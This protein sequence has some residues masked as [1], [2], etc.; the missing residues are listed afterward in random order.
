MRLL[1]VLALFGLAAGGDLRIRLQRRFPSCRG[2]LEGA[3]A[4][5]GYSYLQ[6]LRFSAA[7]MDLSVLSEKDRGE[8]WDDLICG[9]L[10]YSPGKGGLLRSVSA[11]WLRTRLGSGLVLAH[12]GGWSGSSFSGA[13]KSPSIDA[14]LRPARGSW[15][16]DGQGLTG[17]GAELFVGGVDLWLLQGVSRVDPSEGGY[18]RTSGERESRGSLLEVLSALRAEWRFLGLSAASSWPAEDD[19]PSWKRAGVDCRWARESFVLAGELA[20][21]QDS[22]G[23]TTAFWVAPAQELERFRHCFALFGRPEAFPDRRGNVPV[24]EDCDLG[25]RYGLR[26]RPVDGVRVAGRLEG[27]AREGDDETE[28]S[29]E[30]SMRP[31]PRMQAV[32]G[33]RYGWEGAGRSWRSLLKLS[34]EPHAMVGLSTRLQ[35][36]G[37]ADSGEDTTESGSAAELRLS[38]RPA[39][40]L[41]FRVGTVAF[42][43]DGYDSRVY[44]AELAFPGQ[45]GSAALYGGGFLLQGSVSLEAAPGMFV[46]A[47]GLWERRENVETMGSGWE[48]TE[49]DGR[50]TVGLQLDYAFP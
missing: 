9:G 47:R 40:R 23:T 26:C 44:A 28:A 2:V 46:R 17:A 49:G 22:S 20:V 12:P 31:A 18:H 48:E 35:L 50:T 1:L 16:C 27:L 14:R 10:G 33:L 7:G 30:V 19:S 24:G 29:G 3:Y 41:R 34:W 38:Y 43:T 13:S 36:T 21:G 25:A 8:E 11:G 4:G 37:Y 5:D 6:R 42:D 15:A 32:A 39:R 45:F